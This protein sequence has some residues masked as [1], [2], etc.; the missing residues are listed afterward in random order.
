M[1]DRIDEWCRRNSE[2]PVFSSFTLDIAP[3][4]SHTSSSSS[5]ASYIAS[6]NLEDRISALEKEIIAL[7]NERITYIHPVEPAP[8]V[9]SSPVVPSSS[10]HLDHSPSPS[11]FVIPPL[12]AVD[13]PLSPS[14]SQRTPSFSPR[15]SNSTSIGILSSTATHP[16]TSISSSNISNTPRNSTSDSFWQRD[17]LP[18]PSSL[19]IAYLPLQE[20]NFGTAPKKPRQKSSY[21][22]PAPIETSTIAQDIFDRSTNVPTVTLTAEEL[23]SL[24]PEVRTKLRDHISLRHPPPSPIPSTNILASSTL[25]LDHYETY[26][27]SLDTS[28]SRPE[29]PPESLRDRYRSSLL[30]H[31]D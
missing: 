20:P 8:R 30:E 3:S 10:H 7:R 14:T 25:N 23:Y 1:R 26:I 4:T 12:G 27:S 22:S 19:S 24:S 5:H 11:N 31:T 28:I 13:H 6:S 2:N 17:I 15:T 18:F 9:I 29:K 21:H 16:S